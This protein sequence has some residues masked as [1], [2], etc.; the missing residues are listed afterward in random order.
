MKIDIV[1]IKILN[2]IIILIKINL[3]NIIIIYCNI[4]DTE[5]FFVSRFS[6]LL[7][8]IIETWYHT[9]FMYFGIKYFPVTRQYLP[10][11]ITILKMFYDD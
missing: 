2:M 3:H 7:L 8:K 11:F 5:I 1:Y 6:A 10:W 9:L 4:Y